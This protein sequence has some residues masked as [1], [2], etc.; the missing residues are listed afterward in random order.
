MNSEDRK[1][2]LDGLKVGDSVAIRNDGYGITRYRIAN[3]EKITPTRKFIISRIKFDNRG[4]E[5]TKNGMWRIKGEI[6]PVTDDVL[7][8]INRETALSF[9]NSCKFSE[10]DNETIFQVYGLLNQSK[11][12]DK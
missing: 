9:I 7:S 6:V 11:P 1:K 4:N 10:Y 2:W 5:I 3:I 12:K 8:S